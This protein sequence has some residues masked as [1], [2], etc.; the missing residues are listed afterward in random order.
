MRIIRFCFR[1]CSTMNWINF[2]CSILFVFGIGAL[3]SP[4]NAPKSIEEE[5]SGDEVAADPLFLT[6]KESYDDILAADPR[7]LPLLG[8]YGGRCITR[9]HRG[10]S[11]YNWCFTSPTK[12]EY[13]SPDG[14]RTTA[15]GHTCKWNS[16]CT[17][18]NA[19]YTWC[20]TTYGTW[21]YCS[22]H[23]LKDD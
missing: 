22:L 13:C 10:S 7:A 15:S 1:L 14:G 8:S 3:P 6:E 5:I 11:K 18:H 4:R 20:E 16:K 12:W 2:V 17:L 23:D 19:V 9:C 21:D